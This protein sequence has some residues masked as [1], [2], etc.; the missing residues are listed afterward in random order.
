MSEKELRWEVRSEDLRRDP[1]DD[2][3]HRLLGMSWG[4]L[5]LTAWVA[6]LLMNLGFGALYCLGDAPIAHARPG[7]FADAFFFSVQAFSTIGFGSMYPQTVYGHV[8]VTVQTFLALV[9]IAALTG[10]I[11]AKFS[12]PKARVRFSEHLVIGPHDGVPTLAFRMANVRE[13]QIVEATVSVVLAVDDVTHEGG[14]FRRLLDL[15]LVRSRTPTFTMGWV[16]LHPI[17]ED[18]PLRGLSA[19]DMAAKDAGIQVTLTGVDGTVSQPIH[20]RY[21][22]DHQDIAWDHRFVDIIERQPDGT[23][24]IHMRC[25]DEVEPL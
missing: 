13:N 19:E 16:V 18:S 22:Y 20:A 21:F 12:L 25:F 8:L 15:D 10:L 11:F 6:Y 17:T 2:L 23:R 5:L 7:S 9:A 4:R 3:Y 14:T 24:L 1:R